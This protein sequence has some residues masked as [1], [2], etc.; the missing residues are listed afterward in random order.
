LG[1]DENGCQN[2]A[3]YTQSVIICPEIFTATVSTKDITCSGKNDGEISV[4]YTNTYASSEVSY[5]WN[6]RTLCS[7]NSCDTLKN[8]S[9]GVY[10]LTLKVTYTL[11]NTLVKVDSLV[12]D[13]IT[14]SDINGQC[15]IKVFN[16]VSA[17]GDGVNDVM[18]IENIEQFPDNR[19]W[20]YNRW[21]QLIFE[22]SG[23][24][25]TNKA[26]PANGEQSNLSSN[27]YF[28]IIDLG[29]G[30]KPIKGWVELM[31]N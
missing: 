4:E 23:Y 17:N 20:V 15:A 7:D 8:L 1:V 16:G 5:V 21:G 29:N 28:Y 22:T 2:T 18:I 12:L 6:P 26:W 19:V 25:N 14:L 3:T 31:K 11:N 24:D 30:N 9:A 10:Y 27:T 13:P